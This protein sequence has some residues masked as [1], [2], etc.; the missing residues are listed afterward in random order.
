MGT[1]W[2]SILLPFESLT[3]IVPCIW[4]W[5]MP[6]IAAKAISVKIRVTVL[7]FMPSFPSRL[8]LLSGWF[9]NR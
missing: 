9:I 7:F 6:M 5:A 2:P 8:N 4:A 1:V 3:S